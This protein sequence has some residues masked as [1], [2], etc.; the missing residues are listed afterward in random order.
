MSI[1]QR[2]SG[3][4]IAIRQNRALR[5]L[6]R[7][8]SPEARFGAITRAER[9]F[10]LTDDRF[11][12]AFELGRASELA[13]GGAPWE[14]RGPWLD[15][16]ARWYER[17]ASLAG[18]G[19]ASGATAIPDVTSGLWP[20]ELP[21]A[22]RA[23]R[24]ASFRAGLLRVGDFRTRDPAR[25]VELLSSVVAGLATYHPAWYYLGEAYL[26]GGDFDA[27]ERAWRRGLALAPTEEAL[28][29]V[30]AKLPVDRV[31]LCARAGDW[32]GVL[33]Q[34]QRVPAG[35]IP[36]AERLTIEGEAWLS[37]GNTARAERLFRAAIEADPHAVGVRRRL[38]ALS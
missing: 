6:A 21:L 20:V 36:A 15:R 30:L 4:L 26:L 37:L 34:L 31:H 2:L 17:A 7:P 1:L 11:E 29:A 3:Y 16:A 27:A 19:K 8:T 22:E 33:R 13:A 18:R 32:A 9:A 23:R 5:D 14:A 38:R 35:A 10:H 28:H 24:V 25:A 12:L